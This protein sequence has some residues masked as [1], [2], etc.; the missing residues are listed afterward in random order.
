MTLAFQV[1]GNTESG[2]SSWLFTFQT[3]PVMI[4]NKGGQGADTEWALVSR[5]AGEQISNHET[6]MAD[7]A[8][9]GIWKSASLRELS[10]ATV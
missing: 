10:L 2:G 5:Q 7:G 1:A 8:D 6:Q 9:R 3:R 4:K